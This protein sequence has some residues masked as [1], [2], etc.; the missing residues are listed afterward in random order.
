M[1]IH[2]KALLIKNWI[3]W[4]RNKCMS[5][6]EIFI[7]IVTTLFLVIFRKS[8][9]IDTVEQQNFLPDQRTLW[10][11][12]SSFIQ[13]YQTNPKIKIMKS[14][15]TSSHVALAAPQNV[16]TQISSY[17][18]AIQ[19]QVKQ[20]QDESQILSYIKSS[21]YNN[22][23]CFGIYI[24]VFDASSLSFKYSLYFNN[25]I[26]NDNPD[27]PQEDGQNQSTT[28]EE[29]YSQ[30]FKPWFQ[31]GFLQ[32]QNWIDREI[33]KSV[34]GSSSNPT[35]QI[36]MAGQESLPYKSDSFQ[37][38]MQNASNTFFVLPYIYVFLKMTQKLL[39]EK[40]KRIREGMKVMGMK[41]SSFYKSWIITYG[42][43][44]FITCFFQT[45][46]L[47]TSVLK[48]SNFLLILIWL[49]LFCIS[50][51]FQSIF[52]TTFFSSAQM[53]NIFGIIFY[54]IMYMM[55]NFFNQDG[56]S[57]AAKT[58]ASFFSQTGMSFA[59]NV[60]IK[61]EVDGVGIQFSNIQDS[62]KG[63]SVGVV[64]LMCIINILVF[65][66][67]A[68]YFDQ[69]FPNEFG[70]KK[71]PLFFLDC[72][73]NRNQKKT[74]YFNKS[75]LTAENHP[76]F[77]PVDEYLRDQEKKSSCLRLRALEKVYPNGK[78]A[79]KG[80]TLTMY[81]G[82]IFVLLGHNGA[83]KTSTIAMLTG[84]QEITSGSASVFGRDVEDQMKEI[85]KFMGFCPQY[86][87]LFD[88]LTVKE[89]LNLF[90]IFKGMKDKHEISKAV[91]Q[92]IYDVDLMEKCDEYSMNL[93]G[94]Q[95][96]RLSVA[97]AFIGESRLI[98]LDEPTSGM[99]TSARR[100]IW[101]MLKK[102]KTNK[103]VILTTH[104]MDEA[105]FLGDRIAIMND[106]KI[107]CCGSSIF[108][109]N[110]FG[111]G[112]N[113]VI[114]KQQ[115]FG[116]NNNILEMVFKYVPEYKLISNVSAEIQM[117][118]PL[119]YLPQFEQL[120][121]EI[122][123]RKAELGIQT[124]AI[125]ITTLEEVFLKVTHKFDF[126]KNAKEDQED[127]KDQFSIS[128]QKVRDEFTLSFMQL[129]VMLKKRLLYFKRDKKSCICE[130]CLPIFI[131]L[132]GLLLCQIKF[133][134]E[135][136][137]II[138]SDPSSSTLQ[139]PE[140]IYTGSSSAD[141]QNSVQKI[142][143]F[144]PTAFTVTSSN[145]NTTT[146][147]YNLIF[148]NYYNQYIG[149]VFYN[150][151]NSV[152]NV[153]NYT[154]LINT[155]N[156]FGP[157]LFLNTINQAIISQ[158]AKKNVQIEVT[159]RPFPFTQSEYQKALQV[160]GFI[161]SFIFSLGLS[162]IPSSIVQYIVREKE[163]KIKH[164]QL[165]SGLTITI[166]WFSNILVD[167]IKHI[168]PSIFSIMLILAFQVQSLTQN[169]GGAA[170]SILI[171]LYGWAVIPFTYYLSF[172]FENTDSSQ[173]Q[174]F[175]FSFSSGSLLPMI[176]LI[177]QIISST[178]NAGKLIS[179]ILRVIFPTF[180]FGEAVT[181]IGS[182]SA[183]A[184]INDMS[185]NDL[186]AFSVEVAGLNIII[187]FIQ[188][189]V[190]FCLIFV[191]ERF[192]NGLFGNCFSKENQYPYELTR[193]D[194]DVT[195]E[196][197]KVE[198]TNPRSYNVCVRNIRKVFVPS[199][200]RVKVA[201][202][203][204]S[205]GVENGECFTLLGVNGAG[206]TTTFKML[207]GEIKPSDGEIYIMGVNQNESLNKTRQFI[208]Y[209]PQFDAL[210]PLLTAREH[211]EIY[212]SIKGIPNDLQDRLIS[213]KISELDLGYFSEIQAGTYSGGNKRKLSTAIAMIGNPPIILLDEPS[214]G[215]DPAA[216][217]FM[218]SVISN[219]STKRKKTSVILTT[220]S[221]EEA[222]A[223]SSR[224]A[225]QVDGELKCIGTVPHIKYKFGIGYEVEIKFQQIG[226]KQVKSIMNKF[227]IK[228]GKK[229]NE[230]N[231]DHYLEKLESQYLVKRISSKGSGSSLYQQLM[232]SKG[233]YIESL[234]E[235][236][237]V[238]DLGDKVIQYFQQNDFEKVDVIEHFQS[239]YRLRIQA[240]SSI[241]KIFG[242]FEKNKKEFCISQ[243]SIK[244]AS[245]EQIFN[246]FA[247]GRIKINPEYKKNSQPQNKQNENQQ[248]QQKLQQEQQ[249]KQSSLPQIQ[250]DLQQQTQMQQQSINLPAIQEAE[251]KINPD[252]S[253]VIKSS[254]VMI[255]VQNLQQ[256]DQKQPSNNKQLKTLPNQSNKNKGSQKRQA[257]DKRSTSSGSTMGNF[258]Q[259]GNKIRL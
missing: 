175:F 19:Y 41:D 30:Y 172:Q 189:I 116:S 82:Q 164:Q 12:A 87:I 182:T 242:I 6:M 243:Y 118:L 123:Q 71:H 79:V 98:F 240:H 129:K 37:E 59:S 72:C 223:L 145:Q 136:S 206:K 181:K 15:S 81:S 28:T 257:S 247:E 18:Q 55:I 48:N 180:C 158:V 60:F 51:I 66:T 139:N 23:L 119:S 250:T 177:L 38:V 49:Y 152:S 95:K 224:M 32:I 259:K 137:P 256:K 225:I 169:Q 251:L 207:G 131:I 133:I 104:F 222:E 63:I 166:Y 86:D 132:I 205:F 167:F 42:L 190:F 47:C 234:V 68:F 14:C 254:H 17:F 35:F 201:V 249:L 203:R 110:K 2:L 45:I 194:E 236:K 217:R 238:E 235:F 29:M 141:V 218:W 40:E 219:A 102:Y 4:K 140:V 228:P 143:P 43:I 149:S 216:R 138:V 97:M 115:T 230:K 168:I 11:D 67:L 33:L 221:M 160:G 77:E 212:S 74:K 80:V 9:A 99:D 171:I 106:G 187:L 84:M 252:N 178:R 162:F 121:D 22:D 170:M 112:Y 39:T 27:V 204:I 198:R 186:T 127:K 101:E 96:R 231:L 155:N 193:Y 36:Q 56:V 122:D 246:A 179:L 100:H 173:V 78:Y 197:K 13:A 144:I 89:H 50:L 209:C 111:V 44:Y 191:K 73:W 103:I 130:I 156:K 215:M 61:K 7:P 163:L 255:E 174:T 107:Q 93:S 16:Y 248:A 208:G 114:S 20:Y 105:D 1:E 183:V 245:I 213:Q 146:D 53:G 220:H 64:W 150:M 244:Q 90:A 91:D 214:T 233:L 258:S 151:F 237:L 54:L 85:R 227:K 232:S 10:P 200:D 94:G 21:S 52:I 226:F 117:Q 239:F 210:L 26:Y 153:Y 159:M 142:L 92:A 188:G 165:I 253:L 24:N 69:V 199:E 120:F 58:F 57:S 196:M 5:C 134:T 65:G 113:L 202:D 184:L 241:G 3:L 192:Q 8:V 109:K 76:N 229:V 135:S 161:A 62:Y 124:Y 185:P 128:Q 154:C 31:S 147:L 148:K 126:S 25:S 83:G 75:N 125:S 46:F 157:P 211:L 70:Q 176:A 195:Y 108:L 34:A 88:Q